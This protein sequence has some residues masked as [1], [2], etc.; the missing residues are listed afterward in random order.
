MCSVFPAVEYHYLRNWL[1]VHRHW[2]PERAAAYVP[3]YVR[4]L[5]ERYDR[6]GKMTELLRK[7]R[8]GK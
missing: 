6:D 4:R 7:G 5:V 3:A 1:Y 2:K 8:P